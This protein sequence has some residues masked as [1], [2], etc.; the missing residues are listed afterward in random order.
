MSKDAHDHTRVYL[1]VFAALL[2]L[3]VVTV[4]VSRLDLTRPWAIGVGL[5]IACLKGGLVAAYFMHLVSERVTVYSIVGLAAAAFIALLLL[6]WIDMTHPA[7]QSTEPPPAAVESAGRHA[8]TA[9][10]VP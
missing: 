6:P 8:E 7:A 10:H 3:T 5:A 1:A 9:A 2:V 4:A